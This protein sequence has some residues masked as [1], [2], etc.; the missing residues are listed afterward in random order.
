MKNN[1]G[2]WGRLKQ[3][4]EMSRNT[5]TQLWPPQRSA[6]RK[7]DLNMSHLENS[8]TKQSLIRR[9]SREVDGLK[10]KN[11][12]RWCQLIKMWKWKQNNCAN[13]C[14]VCVS[15]WQRCMFTPTELLVSDKTSSLI[16]LY[17]CLVVWVT[18]SLT[19][20]NAQTVSKSGGK[21]E[22]QSQ[23]QRVLQQIIC[24]AY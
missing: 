17:S 6:K 21:P 14:L 10:G 18:S 15:F 19:Q 24:G 22:T 8:T 9:G 3:V 1:Q 20:S 13:C 5:N 11:Q 16:L 7:A 12:H 2:V 4:Y 23:N